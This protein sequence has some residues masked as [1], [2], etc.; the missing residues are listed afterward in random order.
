MRL[1]EIQKKYV[2]IMAGLLAVLLILIGSSYAYLKFF[3]NNTSENTLPSSPT[4]T[5]EAP[6]SSRTPVPGTDSNPPP[7]PSAQSGEEPSR[8]IWTAVFEGCQNDP[9]ADFKSEQTSIPDHVLNAGFLAL[10]KKD[11]AVCASTGSTKD[12]DGSTCEDKYVLLTTLSTVGSDC[13]KIAN[14]DLSISCSANQKKDSAVCAQISDAGRKTVCEA[15]VS[16]DAGKCDGLPADQKGSCSNT[17]VFVKALNS[18]D[19]NVCGQIAVTVSGGIFDRTY[20][21]IVL[22]QDSQKAWNEYYSNSVCV[23]KYAGSVA[24]EKNDVSFCENIPGKD[25]ENKSLY[26]DCVAQFK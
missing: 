3:K 5:T 22:S 10:A 9:E 20:C 21:K 2:L 7:Q 24:K 16:G 19:V 17:V 25:V 8:T 13:G 14:G 11:V 4:T 6:T 1:K 26:A 12:S 23:R 15:V 18:H